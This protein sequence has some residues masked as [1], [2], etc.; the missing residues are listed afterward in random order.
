MKK[1]SFLLIPVGLV[2]LGFMM[3][4]FG[5][6]IF[7]DQ[8]PTQSILFVGDTHF[9]ESYLG[10]PLKEHGYDYSLENYDALL[11][12]ADLVIANLE[13]PL[14]DLKDSPFKGD[15]NYIHFADPQKTPETLL[16]H[17][18]TA[19]SLANNHALD[20]WTTGLEQT[21]DMLDDYNIESFGAG[22]TSAD[23]AAPFIYELGD[24]TLAVIGA[25]EFD[26]IYDTR[27]KFYATEERG[28]VNR[29]SV[30][31]I[32]DQIEQIRENYP[33]AFIVISPHW[34]ANYEPTIDQRQRTISTRLMDSG[35]KLI[36]G[37]GG[38]LFQDIE[39]HENGWMVYGIGNFVFNSPG[40]YAEV[41]ALPYSLISRLIIKEGRAYSLRLY[42]IM[43]DNLVTDYQGNFVDEEA[44]NK[45]MDRLEQE[46]VKRG[47]DEFGYFVELFLDFTQ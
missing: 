35:A 3:N 40:R 27:Y 13:T 17:N 12:S 45:V 5:L 29:L 24:F 46:G 14:T 23:A 33:E 44:F 34:T 41:E 20:Y 43:S 25:F 31:Q 16:S 26:E 32:T 10:N 6:N 9:G 22:L 38:H 2:L 18:I 19:V 15:K 7:Q 36:L 11:R 37:H 39:R 28:G 1:I 42:P 47:K 30:P 4:G 21:F 8:G